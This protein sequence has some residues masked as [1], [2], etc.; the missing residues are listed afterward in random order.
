MDITSQ[1][2]GLEMNRSHLSRSTCT[3]TY[4]ANVRTAEKKVDDRSISRKRIGQ[5]RTEIALARLSLY[6][7]RQD[8]LQMVVGW[9][10]THDS[11]W[12]ESTETLYYAGQDL[13]GNDRDVAMLGHERLD[14]RNLGAY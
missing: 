10:S 12:F 7:G 5:D 13:I 4:R 11:I 14:H 8:A 3:S 6:L 1:G 2:E 9:S